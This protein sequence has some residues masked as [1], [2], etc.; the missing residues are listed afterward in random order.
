MQKS[1]DL[2]MPQPSTQN[3]NIIFAPRGKYPDIVLLLSKYLHIVIEK[4][5]LH[6][7]I[8]PMHLLYIFHIIIL[9][10]TPLKVRDFYV[11]I[12]SHICFFQVWQVNIVL[13]ATKI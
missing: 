9:S 11:P 10:K 7:K 13:R 2:P 3:Q 4:A 8:V 5:L 12:L 6:Q 1:F